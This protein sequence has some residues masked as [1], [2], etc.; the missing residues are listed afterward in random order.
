MGWCIEIRD[1][2]T[3]RPLR[4][5]RKI[6]LSFYIY[7]DRCALREVPRDGLDSIPNLPYITICPISGVC[8][9]PSVEKGVPFDV[10]R[11]EGLGG[12]KSVYP[13][14]EMAVGDSVFYE[15]KSQGMVAYESAKKYQK[16]A[17]DRKFSSRRQ[18][19]GVRIWR[20]S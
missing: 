17:G 7:G 12:R 1:T 8:D 3:N 19:G 20:I 5:K 6:I 4:M 2:D 11:F 9:M 13:F 14:M 16:R 15:D 10:E 18:D